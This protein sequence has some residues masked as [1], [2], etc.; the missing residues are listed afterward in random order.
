MIRA[1][2]KATTEQRMI[3]Y[4]HGA[5]A[6]ANALIISDYE[7]GVISPRIIEQILPEARER[8]LVVTVDAHGDLAASLVVSRLGAATTTP[9]EL[10]DLLDHQI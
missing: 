10:V 7:N 4:L 5:M 6:T 8:G 9:Q 2:L 1:D 3:D